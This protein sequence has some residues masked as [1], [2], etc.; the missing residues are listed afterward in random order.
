MELPEYVDDK[1]GRI[2]RT[3]REHVTFTWTIINFSKLNCEKLYSQTFLVDNTPWRILL[4]PRGQGYMTK[5]LT[6]YLCVG[7]SH[8]LSGGCYTNPTNFQITILNHHQ[9][10]LDSHRIGNYGYGKYNREKLPSFDRRQFLTLFNFHE[11][12][13]LMD[14]TCTIIAEASVK[15]H[16]T[17]H[18]HLIMK[19]IMSSFELVDFRDLCKVEKRFVQLLEEAC[20]YHPILIEN[21]KKRNRTKKFIEWS[22]T[23]LG[24]VLHFL[25]T[26]SVEN[27]NDDACNELQ[28]LWEELKTF[29][30]DDLTWLELHVLD[31]LSMRTH[32]E[33]DLH[34]AKMEESRMAA[35]GGII[36]SVVKGLITCCQPEEIKIDE[37][38]TVE[39]KNCIGE[40]VTYTW[41]IKNFSKWNG[42][43]DLK[44]SSNE[45]SVGLYSG[46]IV[47]QRERWY[48]K[49][50][51]TIQMCR[52]KYPC[53]F[54]ILSSTI[55]VLN[56]FDNMNKTRGSSILEYKFE[57]GLDEFCDPSKGYVV[58]DTCI[59]VAEVF[60][61]LSSNYPTLPKLR[62][63]YY[64][65]DIYRS[66]TDFKNLCK[67]EKFSVPQLEELFKQLFVTWRD[68][69]K[70]LEKSKR[71][72]KY[73][74]W[75]MD[76]LY[77]VSHFL[78]SH[79]V[80]DMNDD[81]CK[82]LQI[83]LEELKT[84]G[85]DEFSWMNFDLSAELE[86]KFWRGYKFII[87]VE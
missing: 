59:V 68:G 77:R 55:Y 26:T 50:C 37:E 64:S 42:C 44:L 78:K 46:R 40:K 85:F 87:T 15:K 19:G 51:L 57:I 34:A 84:F 75:S 62:I 74:E 86:T 28:N 63:K 43:K 58:N 83:L 79:S 14:D 65:F 7:D 38:G 9:Q 35:N 66:I 47:M 49:E 18:S 71:S 23:A 81:A 24:R 25:D 45:F 3:M 76:A 30:F 54:L 11:N 67:T 21:Q 41:T 4:Y 27:M 69:I 39:T 32:M 12:G 52:G 33:V 2:E 22:F 1:E 8:S 16:G 82:E 5:R 73:I 20:S 31:A 70:H 61:N 56:Q 60:Y 36:E 48:Q 10:S 29:G 17:D 53:Y 13:Y 80:K 72:Q 6:M